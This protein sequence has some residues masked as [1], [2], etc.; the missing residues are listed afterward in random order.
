[1]ATR[2]V[3]G[4]RQADG[5][6][7]RHRASEQPA[8]SKSDRRGLISVPLTRQSAQGSTL[9]GDR[10]FGIHL[11]PADILG[12]AQT[13]PLQAE[14]PAV[15]RG[16]ARLASAET[17]VPFVTVLTAADRPFRRD[18]YLASMLAVLVR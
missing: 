14:K 18:G 4:D 5:S 7:A 9:T 17:I 11:P 15:P 8:L 13:R 2:Y 6:A 10:K 3:A 16:C 1:V 12:L